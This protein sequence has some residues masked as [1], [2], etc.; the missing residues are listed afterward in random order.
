MLLY[1]TPTTKSSSMQLRTDA[2]S[3]RI[4]RLQLTAYA[5]FDV[6]APNTSILSSSHF[7]PLFQH[8]STISSL[9]LLLLLAHHQITTAH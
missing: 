4:P 6:H 3:N 5:L 7:S 9:L 2:V 1:R 8:S